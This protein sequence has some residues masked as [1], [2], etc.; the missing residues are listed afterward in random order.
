MRFLL[1]HLF[2]IIY[3]LLYDNFVSWNFSTSGSVNGLEMGVVRYTAELVQRWQ[4]SV[5][6]RNPYRRPLADH[7]PQMASAL[8]LGVVQ[9]AVRV[10][11][12]W[13]RNNFINSHHL[14]FSRCP[15]EVICFA[16]MSGPP[17][18]IQR[19]QIGLL[20]QPVPFPSGPSL[21]SGIY[22]ACVFQC[23]PANMLASLR[24]WN[25]FALL[26]RSLHKGLTYD[27]ELTQPSYIVLLI[28][29]LRVGTQLSS[30][31]REREWRLGGTF[32][33][34]CR[35]AATYA[36][37]RAQLAGASF[38]RDNFHPC[39]IHIFLI[40]A[41]ERRYRPH[42]AVN[43]LTYG[44]GFLRNFIFKNV[45]MWSSTRRFWARF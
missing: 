24:T 36:T 7:A 13:A 19:R 8:C 27:T 10:T 34:W 2:Q 11:S 45:H 5:V 14:T 38:G 30:S 29:K 21:D 4:L 33:G 1:I 28:R 18:P 12:A 15:V 39:A 25:P 31:R 3:L 41:C 9:V 43:S 40:S 35:R 26:L 20:L 6:C 16:E 23:F 37:S 42:Q 22:I 44:F 32:Q 17:V